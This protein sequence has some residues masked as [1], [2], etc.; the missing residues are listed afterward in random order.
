M[1]SA[2]YVLGAAGQ[3]LSESGEFSP[4]IEVSGDGNSVETHPQNADFQKP[5]INEVM[6]EVS[7]G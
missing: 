2:A 7:R 4:W 3:P 1:I 6:E 5:D